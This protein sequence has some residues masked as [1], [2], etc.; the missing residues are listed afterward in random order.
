MNSAWINCFPKCPGVG[1]FT[2]PGEREGGRREGEG[3]EGERERERE[4]VTDR[5][6]GREREREGGRED[7]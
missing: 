2:K 7:R 3:G 1:V 6:R 5:Q 4:R